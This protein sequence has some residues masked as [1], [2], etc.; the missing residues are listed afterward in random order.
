MLFLFAAMICQKFIE[1][2]ENEKK[3]KD[4]DFLASLVELTEKQVKIKA[5]KAN[6]LA[7]TQ[8]IK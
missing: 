7:T 8:Q 5:T 3:K 2:L 6:L 4:E 1:Y